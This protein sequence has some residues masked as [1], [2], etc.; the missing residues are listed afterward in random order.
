[1]LHR[2]FLPVLQGTTTLGVGNRVCVPWV[3]HFS[4]L[5]ETRQDVVPGGGIGESGMRD[6]DVDCGSD[7]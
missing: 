6:V 1:M 3:V 2:T 5:E 4:P 7:V